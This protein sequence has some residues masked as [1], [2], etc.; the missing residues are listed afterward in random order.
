MIYDYKS[1]ILEEEEEERECVWQNMAMIYEYQS[2][3]MIY[4]H[5]S[6]GM[7]YEYKSIYLKKKSMSVTK[8]PRLCVC[9]YVHVVFKTMIV[10][11]M[12]P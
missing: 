11:V 5:K 6:M 1:N 8:F 4:E 12:C 10:C 3:A 9:M 7:I 2:M